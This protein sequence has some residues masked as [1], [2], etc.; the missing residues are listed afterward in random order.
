MIVTG[1]SIMFAISSITFSR[2]ADFLPIRRLLAVGLLT[3]GLAAVAGLFSTSFWFL[4]AVRVIQASGAGAIVSLSLVLLTR[5]VPIQRRG[6][7]MALIMSAV[8]LGLGLGPVAGGAIVEYWGWR[9]LF[10]V[11]ALTLVLVPFFS[12]TYRRRKRRAAPSIP[13]APYLSP[14]ARPGCCCF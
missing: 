13:P 6:K 8:S 5:Y 2:L 11:T 1:Y 14:S 4:L 10:V 7:A 3:L 9:Y 12:S